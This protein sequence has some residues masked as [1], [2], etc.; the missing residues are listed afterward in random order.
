MQ[1]I[2]ARTA[3]KDYTVLKCK[4]TIQTVHSLA[5]VHYLRLLFFPL[6]VVSRTAALCS[7]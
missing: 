3:Y 1:S 6:S 7:T 5:Y 4:S 2:V